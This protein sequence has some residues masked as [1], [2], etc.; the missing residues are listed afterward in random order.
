ML[1]RTSCL[2]VVILALCSLLEGVTGLAAGLAATVESAAPTLQTPSSAGRPG[3]G[4]VGGLRRRRGLS[5]VGLLEEVR[6]G[7]NDDSRAG[8]GITLSPGLLVACFTVVNLFNY[9]D[10]GMV[11]GVLP[12]LGEDFEVHQNPSIESS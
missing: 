4:S 10:R 6:G 12:H 9:M 2:P 5:A 11:N 8:K 3:A 7:G 1:A